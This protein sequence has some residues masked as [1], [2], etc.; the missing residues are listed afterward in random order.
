[1]AVLGLLAACG[2]DT[3]R[4]FGFTRDAPDEFTTARRVPLSLPPDYALRPPSPGA[5]RPQ[6]SS[7]RDGAEATL[8]GVTSAAT[9]SGTLSRGEEMLLQE[10]GQAPSTP[11]D[12]LR[13]RVD[14]ESRRLDM[15]S[16]SLADRMIFWQPA[17]QPGTPVDPT[18][19]A[20]R[21]RENAAL[22]REVTVG[23]TPIIQRR[24][25]GL[26]EGLF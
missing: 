6:E 11:S 19:E 25:K 1:M 4:T 22:G 9:A 5:P 7:A 23:D 24:R 13:R 15:P 3:S 8:L 16:R 21:L 2:A 18:A 26:L 12:V 17:P 10:A 14:E 20:R